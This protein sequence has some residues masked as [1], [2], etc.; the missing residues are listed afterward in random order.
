MKHNFGVP[1]TCRF[2]GAGFMVPVSWCRFHG[3]GLVVGG[4]AGLLGEIPRWPTVF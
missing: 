4:L 2:H 3:G 1:A